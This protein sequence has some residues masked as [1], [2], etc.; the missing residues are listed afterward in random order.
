[1]QIKPME[2]ISECL[3]LLRS[4]LPAMVRLEAHLPDKC[5]PIKGNETQLQQVLMNLCTNAWHALR[6]NG[7]I[8]VTVDDVSFTSELRKGAV[9]IPAGNYLRICVSDN[10][11][12]M[13][14]EVQARIFDPFFTTK[15]PGVG[16]GLG[17]SVVH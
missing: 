3:R 8:S 6:D 2:V 15:A 11:S 13:S 17:L 14:A 9:T 16:T 10:G 5:S 4:T 1:Q 12:G 7:Q